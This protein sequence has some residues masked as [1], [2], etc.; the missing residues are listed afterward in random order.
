MPW[1]SALGLGITDPAAPRH[2][3]QRSSERRW[4]PPSQTSERHGQLKGPKKNVTQ[5]PGLRGNLQSGDFCIARS[6]YIRYW[7]GVGCSCKTL[8]KKHRIQ[9]ISN[10]HRRGQNDVTI[11]SN[12]TLR[13]K[14]Q[15]SCNPLFGNIWSRTQLWFPLWFPFPIPLAASSKFHG[16]ASIVQ[17]PSHP[18]HTTENQQ[19]GWTQWTIWPVESLSGLQRWHIH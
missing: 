11:H 15:G 7:M 10:L 1:P 2:L 13:V 18:G 19:M 17:L 14:L 4:S 12:K 6:S 8:K 3:C 9:A 5:I 16:E